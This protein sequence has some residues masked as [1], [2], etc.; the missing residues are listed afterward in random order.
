MI[1]KIEE[2]KT[3]KNAYEA[4]YDAGKNGAD[5]FNSHY[6]WF[7]TKESMQEWERGKISAEIKEGI[8]KSIHP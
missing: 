4:G 3:F 7:R 5:N 1:N 2:F 8:V 6:K